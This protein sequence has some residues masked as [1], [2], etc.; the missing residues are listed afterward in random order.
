MSRK[1]RRQIDRIRAKCQT[2]NAYDRMIRDEL[3]AKLAEEQPPPP[4]K[5]KRKLLGRR[6]FHDYWS[7]MLSHAWQMKRQQAFEKYGR[8]CQEC[9]SKMNVVVHHK[10][11]ERLYRER[12]VDLEILCEGCHAL[13]H[14]GTAFLASALN[15]EYLA[16]VG[17]Q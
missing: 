9:G 1:S 7:Y 2:G 17:R 5:K 16:I 4:P 11:Y 12:L 14:E 10:S 3:L 8:A 15:R 13:R 6:K